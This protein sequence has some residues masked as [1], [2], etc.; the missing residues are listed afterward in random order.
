[1]YNES[2]I[3]QFNEYFIN[4]NKIKRLEEL[5]YNLPLN[6]I[7]GLNKNQIVIG[8]TSIDIPEN[9]T[10]NKIENNIKLDSYTND[11]DLVYYV[12]P[13]YK[14]YYQ[15]G[16]SFSV[17]EFN[18]SYNEILKF[19]FNFNQQD[20]LKANFV[21]IEFSKDR[22]LQARKYETLNNIRILPHS[23]T[24]QLKIFIAP[25]NS[26]FIYNLD[27]NLIKENMTILNDYQ[28]EVNSDIIY[29]PDDRVSMVSNNNN[30][31][32]SVPNL[33]KNFIY[34]SYAIENNS[35]NRIPEHS[36]INVE[37]KNLYQIYS[38]YELHDEID[39]TPTIIEYNKQGK[40]N[41]IKLKN[42]SQFIKFQDDTT[43][44][45]LSYRFSGV[46]KVEIKP[47]NIK[48][49]QTESDFEEVK[50]KSRYEIDTHMKT[51]KSVRDL[52]MAVIMDEFT[53][54]SYKFE[55]DL[56][57]LTFDNWKNEIISFMPHF[58]FIESSWH[59]NNG[60][61]S[62]KIAFVTEEKH[63]YIKELIT[64]A[65]SM[66]IPIV[67]WNKEDPVHFDHFIDTAKLCDFIFTTD[68][69]RVEDYKTACNHENVDVLQFAAQPV[70]HN[71]VKIQKERVDGISFAGS[72]YTL[73]EER[74]RDMDRLFRASIP[75]NLNI[76][77]RNYEFT[78]RGEKLNFLFPE[79]FRE[80]IL[81]T[82]PFY[83]I[84]KAYKGYK[85]MININTVKTSPTMYA[86]RVYEGLASGTPIISNYS[87]G[88]EKQFGDIIGYSE[89]EK[90]LVKYL[91][92]LNDDE[93]EYNKVKQLGL[94]RVLSEH[95]YSIRLSQI[96]AKLGYE[97]QK[98]KPKVAFITFVENDTGL[99]KAKDIFN[100][101]EYEN[102]ELF[103]MVNNE[104]ND[105]T[106]LKKDITVMQVDRA[107]QY[108]ET[109]SK[110]IVADYIAPINI[111]DFY[112]KN[113]LT[114][115]LLTTLY[116]DA[117]VIG[118]NNYFINENN[119]LNEVNQ[120]SE[121]EYV[122]SVNSDASIIKMDVF[123]N[124]SFNESIEFLCGERSLSQ[125]NFLGVKIYSSDK[126]NY[127]QNGSSI[128]KK[129]KE[130][131]IV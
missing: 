37:S 68:S 106:S 56:L 74:S 49:F 25:E 1:M 131:V 95:T 125:L 36:L 93:N 98:A 87:L 114:D 50:W 61:W 119:L 67:F 72:Y 14:K 60:D 5:S 19:N 20:D 64:F 118:K 53:Y 109:I 17:D 107:T 113:Y 42:E 31:D 54:H 129:E 13:K 62:K 69:D 51:I 123:L 24:E 40:T 28:L 84:E 4:H 127:I 66:N 121:H 18:L 88:M 30:L 3:N 70:N 27:F 99:E 130:K 112:G 21:V 73:R 7:S 32:I 91:T 16:K 128:E 26:G 83:E 41:L 8:R 104:F 65:K 43:A 47:V 111:S 89:D 52:R 90:E 29:N 80:Y 59:G 97:I 85:Y 108:F 2:V 15:L 63:R 122:Q 110:L 10:E 105:Y 116:T 44:I 9:I 78:K 101:I 124:F 45:R 39:F 33:N 77:D 57:R 75:Y 115:L 58:I 46:G 71:P 55:A 102:K 6:K 92:K 117:E 35:F 38:P 94:R 79:E 22:G 34:F 103:V 12:D 120:K 86:R 82:L 48:E 96:A 11:D 126:V 81:G 23:E 76:Y 100:N